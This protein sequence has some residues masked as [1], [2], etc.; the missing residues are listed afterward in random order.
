MGSTKLYKCL[1]TAQKLKKR[2]AWSDGVLKLNVV[3][4]SCSLYALNCNYND[5]YDSS[6]SQTPLL[7]MCSKMLEQKQLTSELELSGILAGSVTGI[8]YENY[9]VDEIEPDNTVAGSGAVSLPVVSATQAPVATAS[10][11]PTV[12]VKAAHSIP[13]KK[14]K[15]PSSVA[16]KPVE[17]MYCD[18]STAASDFSIGANGD[19]QGIDRFP[20]LG[21]G[22]VNRPHTNRSIRNVDYGNTSTVMPAS[23]ANVIVPF[24]RD[25]VEAQASRRSAGFGTSKKYSFAESELDD[26]WGDGGGGDGDGDNEDRAGDCGD[27]S[28]GRCDI[29]SVFDGGVGGSDRNDHNDHSIAALGSTGGEGDERGNAYYPHQVNVQQS[30]YAVKVQE[31]SSNVCWRQEQDH[32]P[33]TPQLS[34]VLGVQPVGSGVVEDWDNF[35]PD[36]FTVQTV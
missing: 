10:P 31:L 34:E 36:A 5:I 2:K 8:E 24:T 14:F 21:G 19:A 27:G 35:D 12:H 4:R 6:K 30:N 1:Y 29:G 9:L 32:L 7:E 26:I 28:D 18:R 25:S 23:D 15:V 33:A 20:F 22:P 11:R 16:P 13:L 3:T 17:P